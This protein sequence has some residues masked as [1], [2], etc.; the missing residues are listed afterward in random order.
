MATMLVHSSVVKM[1]QA[2]NEEQMVE[3]VEVIAQCLGDGK[4]RRAQP[5]AAD[6]STFGNPSSLSPLKHAWTTRCI[7]WVENGQDIARYGK[8]G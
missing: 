8:F 5:R 4:R 2:E 3:A 7:K 1:A 6:W